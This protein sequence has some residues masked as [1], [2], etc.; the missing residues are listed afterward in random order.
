MSVKLSERELGLLNKAI[1][2]ML[3]PGEAEEF[4]RLLTGRSDVRS[5]YE[6]L[7]SVKEATMEMKFKQPPEET[8]D[9]Y[10]AGVYSRLERGIAWLLI[11]IG[12]AVVLAIVGYGAVM[13]FLGD[14]STPLA[15]KLGVGVLLLG[16]A[17]LLVSVLREKLM[18]RKKD[19]YKEVIR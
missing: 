9:R 11:S 6:S 3:S 5:E 15:V 4:R 14:T 2:C 16:G 7:K 8:W 18:I 13:K 1:D 19:K 12:A 17:V 10:W